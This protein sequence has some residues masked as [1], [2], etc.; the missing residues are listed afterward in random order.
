M[1]S[2]NT[3]FICSGHVK[4][5]ASKI[6][7][8][9]AKSFSGKWEYEFNDDIV[10]YFEDESFRKN[11]IQYY[12]LKAAGNIGLKERV[13]YAN[14]IVPDLYLEIHHDSAQESDIK[15][16]M[17]EGENSILWNEI[18][19]FSLHYS[20]QNCCPE[21]SKAFAQMVADEL[22]K[23]GFTPNLYHANIE[24]M[25]CVDRKRGIYNRIPPMG[26]YV[27]YNVKNPAVVIECGTIINP[28][29]EKFLTN[30][31]TRKK[32]AEAIHRSVMQYFGNN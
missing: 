20:E 4:E 21:R 16:A 22:L 5:P 7:H 32:I 9:G 19:G 31:D 12:V 10:Q 28:H 18:Q 30:N 24:N 25:Q 13:E 2:V 27:L 23:H 8:K 1:E 11:D 6:D 17:N 14:T 3:V 15:K 29:E 26:L